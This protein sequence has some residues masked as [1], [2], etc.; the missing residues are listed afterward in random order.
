MTNVNCNHPRVTVKVKARP[1]TYYDPPEVE[2]SGICDE[3]VKFF[4]CYEDLP[5]EA[6]CRDENGRLLE[7]E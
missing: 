3:C 1:A 6:V 2:M 5:K 7:I 4:S